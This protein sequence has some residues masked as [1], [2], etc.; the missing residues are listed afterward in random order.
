MLLSRDTTGA[1]PCWQ[2]NTRFQSPQSQIQ[3]W[4]PCPETTRLSGLMGV[5]GSRRAGQ[6]F[7][8]ESSRRSENDPP[9]SDADD[10]VFFRIFAALEFTAFA[11][12][13][14]STY[15]NRHP[16]SALPP[17]PHNFSGSTMLGSTVLE[18]AIG[19]VFVYLVFSLIASAIAEYISSLLDRR[20][21]HL[22]HILFN[23]FDNDDPQGRTMLNLFIAHPMIQALNSTNWKPQFQSA[24]ERVEQKVEQFDL[25]RNKWNAAAAAV[26]A[27]DEAR[28]AAAKATDVA[29]V[30][31]TAVAKVK[32]IQKGPAT[33]GATASPDLLNA[34]DAAAAA[35]SAADASATVARETAA[36]A[37]AAAELLARVK[38]WRETPAGFAV[39][40]PARRTP[41]PAA[42]VVPPKATD[43]PAPPVPSASELAA[44]ATPDYRS[45][46]ESRAGR[47]RGRRRSDQCGQGSRYGQAQ[48]STAP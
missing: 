31:T 46:N 4:H 44:R 2:Q 12:V 45:G 23:L 15:L 37:T 27:A 3:K 1:R 20:S 34:V 39:Q 7:A 22:K 6:A 16:F 18:T 35:T 17:R 42:Q 29:A 32:D 11:A 21:D 10:F 14:A 26:A 5:R 41:A 43:A 36:K 28:A 30:A 48:A 40:P 24:A 13:H 9:P 47:N 33:M 8:T 19:L 38:K 25:A